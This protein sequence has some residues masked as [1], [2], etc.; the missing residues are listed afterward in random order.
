[1]RAAARAAIARAGPTSTARDTG[2]GW[3]RPRSSAPFARSAGDG[4]EAGAA[5]R[6]TTCTSQPPGISASANARAAPRG[7][8]L[9]FAYA[10]AVA[11]GCFISTGRSLEEAIERVKLAESLG[12]ESVY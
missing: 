11:T 5:R 2:P 4:A 1:M 12:Y 8:A 6:R 10:P 7:R 9:R 3:S